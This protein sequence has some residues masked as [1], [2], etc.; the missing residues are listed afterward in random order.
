MIIF[1]E[2][3]AIF[4]VST[5][6]GWNLVIRRNIARLKSA[7]ENLLLNGEGEY[8]GAKSALLCYQNKKTTKIAWQ[9]IYSDRTVGFR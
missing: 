6:G 7:N 9:F 4:Y 8:G 3:G 1:A 5:T 2:E